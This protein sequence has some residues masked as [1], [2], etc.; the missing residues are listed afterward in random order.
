MN[1]RAGFGFFGLKTSAVWLIFI[2]WKKNGWYLI[3]VVCNYSM[4]WLANMF[5]P[6]G[7][8]LRLRIED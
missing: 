3:V 7:H 8:F 4:A 5:K 1:L 6:W 2:I